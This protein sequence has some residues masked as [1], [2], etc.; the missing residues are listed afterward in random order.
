M[1]GVATGGGGS[2]GHVGTVSQVGKFGNPTKVI[3]ATPEHNVAE[4]LFEKFKE[5]GKYLGAKTTK[6]EPTHEQRSRL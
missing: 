5:G 4:R 6:I 2:R 1:E 3:D